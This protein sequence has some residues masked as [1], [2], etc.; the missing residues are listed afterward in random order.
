MESACSMR[1]ISTFMEVFY[2]FNL[3]SLDITLL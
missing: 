3:T 2:E 1:A